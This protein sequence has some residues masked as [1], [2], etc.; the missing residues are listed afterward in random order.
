M[1]LAH[2]IT[3]D[4]T[5]KQRRYFNQAAGCARF[6]YNW[7]LAQWNKDYKKGKKP[8]A[9][10]LRKAFNK[11][12]YKKFPWMENIHRDAHSRPFTNLDKAYNNFFKKRGAHPT[13][14]K[15]GQKDSFYLANDVF[16]IE[17]NRVRLPVI[18]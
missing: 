9:R 5:F 2:V 8:N 11:I 1:I 13:F 3:L 6:V 14:H 15:K 4:P 18:G 7:A 10:K 16:H 12:K 17:D